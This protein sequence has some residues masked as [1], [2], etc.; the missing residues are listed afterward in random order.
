MNQEL[1]EVLDMAE[2]GESFK[3]VFCCDHMLCGALC[4]AVP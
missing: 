4:V 1:S 3:L 2:M